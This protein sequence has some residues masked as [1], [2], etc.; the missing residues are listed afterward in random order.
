[1]AFVERRELLCGE[2]DLGEAVR[3][4]HDRGCDRMLFV[5]C[6]PRSSLKF[7]EER[8]ARL[9]PTMG[10]DAGLFEVANVREQCAWQHP[11]REAATGKAVDLVRM[12]HA[13]LKTDEPVP[14]PVAIPQRALVVGA[15][16]AG[17]QTAKDLAAAAKA[18]M[19]AQREAKRA[20]YEARRAAAQAARGEE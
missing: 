2:S 6:S 7:P 19:Q 1:M 5:G 20:E 11:D 9:M 8:I 10:L 14:A 16:A 18:K 4:L 17:L 12:A 3:Q 13:R 15:G